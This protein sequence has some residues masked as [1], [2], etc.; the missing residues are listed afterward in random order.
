M[1]QLREQQQN[2]RLEPSIG[3]V[4]AAGWENRSLLSKQSTS[5]ANHPASSYQTVNRGWRVEKKG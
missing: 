4:P 5:R 3:G 1:R 2:D